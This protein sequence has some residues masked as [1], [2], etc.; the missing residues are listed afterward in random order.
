MPQADRPGQR[1]RKPPSSNPASRSPEASPATGCPVGRDTCTAPGLDPIRN[2]MDYTAD[3]C[4][5]E[6]TPGQVT[7]MQAQ[8]A[9]YRG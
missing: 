5:N 8:L 1:T 2:Y 4:M 3:A 6:F 7:R 9:T